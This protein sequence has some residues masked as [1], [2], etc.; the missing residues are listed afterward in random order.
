MK[1]YWKTFAKV[2]FKFPGKSRADRAERPSIKPRAFSTRAQLTTAL[3]SSGPPH[4]ADGPFISTAVRLRQR[5]AGKSP[6]I[7]STNLQP[8][9]VPINIG[10]AFIVTVTRADPIV[11]RKPRQEVNLLKYNKSFQGLV[12]SLNAW[13]C[14]LEQSGL[15]YHRRDPGHGVFLLCCLVSLVLRTL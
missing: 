2:G 8:V 3:W 14:F 15:S 13:S 4:R 7:P 12:L 9:P 6:K 11:Q 10:A 5:K 1:R